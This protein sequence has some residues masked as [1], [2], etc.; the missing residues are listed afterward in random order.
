[1]D[2][3]AVL[4]HEGKLPQSIEGAYREMASLTTW[5]A[6][7]CPELQTICVHSRAW[8]EA[9]GSAV[10]ELAFSLAMGVEY[11]RAMSAR[12]LDVEL[13]AP[14]LRFAVTVGSNFFR[15]IAKLRALRML[16][17]RAVAVCGASEQ[18]QNCWIHV[19][20]SHWN[21]TL[22]DPYNNI[23]RATVEAFAGV[24]GSC[25]SMQVGAFDE[26]FRRPDDFSLRIARNTQ[27]ILQQECH[28]DHV[29]DP[30]GGSWF[31]ESLTSELAGKAWALFQ[32]VEKLG[33]I[34]AALRQGFPQNKV[35]ETAAEKSKA[36]CR[37]RDSIVGVNQYANPK[38]KLLDR[39][40]VDAA[41]FHKR[42]VQQVS[43]YRTSL[44]EDESELVLQ[45][46]ARILETKGSDLFD[47]CA[48]AAAAGATVGEITRAVRISDSP[49]PPVAPLEIRRAA[50]PIEALRDATQRLTASSGKAPIA[51]LCNMGGLRDYK[52]RADFSRGFMAVA[53]F[54][55][56]YSK[57]FKSPEEAA[58][59]FGSSGA[60]LAV[61]CS[62]DDNYPTVV[63]PLVKTL[64]AAKADAVVVL[65]GYPEKMVEEFRKQGV[66]EFIHIRADACELL[67]K[68]QSRL[69]IR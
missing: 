18:A 17:S 47:V 41:A 1:M 38:E 6:H 67:S 11:L 50:V 57:G 36:I 45:K 61:I 52:A 42:R 40:A 48:E 51:F 8:H 10:Q 16:W 43:S 9:G 22:Y 69:G 63:P 15:E 23:V 56:V 4:A 2:P 3:L 30:A 59:A 39:P 34:E 46:L 5:A 58:A 12:G 54:E 66:D 20:T 24:L 49:S 13:V 68:L 7:N 26:V 32:E 21:K 53:G 33:G 60:N 27:L 29:I 31:V 28:L 35:S 44:E 64:R 14:R 62:S 19:R 37:R 65:A 55:S 25:D